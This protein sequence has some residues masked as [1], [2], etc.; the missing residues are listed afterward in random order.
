MAVP[1]ALVLVVKIPNVDIVSGQG[2]L[3]RIQC[4][5]YER[6]RARCRRDVAYKAIKAIVWL[7]F[8]EIPQQL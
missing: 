5:I 6:Q 1:I 2:W 4:R 7:A 8:C 3:E